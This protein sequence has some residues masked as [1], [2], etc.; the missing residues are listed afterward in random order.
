[1]NSASINKMIFCSR[2]LMPTLQAVC[3]GPSEMIQRHLN[4]NF[5]QTLLT[6]VPSKVLEL[7]PILQNVTKLGEFWHQNDRFKIENW[8]N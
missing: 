3:N 8:L 7:G 2:K 1:M 4:G 6:S 5:S